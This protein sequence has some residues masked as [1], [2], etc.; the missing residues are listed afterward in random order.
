MNFGYIYLPGYNVMQRIVSR[1]VCGSEC[2]IVAIQRRYSREDGFSE[3]NNSHSSIMSSLSYGTARGGTPK[4]WQDGKCATHLRDNFKNHKLMKAT[5]N[6][7]VG[8]RSKLR[9]FVNMIKEINK[10]QDNNCDIGPLSTAVAISVGNSQITK[11]TNDEVGHTV[12]DVVVK[13]YDQV[14]KKIKKYPKK[15]F[16]YPTSAIMHSYI[17]AGMPERCRGVY[18]DMVASNIPIE[19]AHYALLV[20][21]VSKMGDYDGVATFL[22]M[23]FSKRIE[24][25]QQSAHAIVDSMETYQKTKELIRTLVRQQLGIYVDAKMAATLLSRVLT[26]LGLARWGV[27]DAENKV[28]KKDRETI[29]NNKIDALHFIKA[30]GVM[31][32]SELTACLINISAV[33][34]DFNTGYKLFSSVN[35]SE[36]CFYCYSTFLSCCAYAL[37]LKNTSRN[38]LLLAEVAFSKAEYRSISSRSSLLSECLMDVYSSKPDAHRAKLL[39]EYIKKSEANTKPSKLTMDYLEEAQQADRRNEALK[40]RV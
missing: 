2:R 16:I 11:T 32:D 9:M 24:I 19:S 8:D 10:M 30:H 33:L 22:K 7:V 13:F 18:N 17:R 20:K 36:K 23:M 35:E 29:Q 12:L 1:L 31:H 4:G 39:L 34:R 28:S 21:S 15:S 37:R 25:S 40:R 26:E 6:R 27:Y 5:P 14:F 38:W 3:N